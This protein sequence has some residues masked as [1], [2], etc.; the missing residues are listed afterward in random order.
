MTHEPITREP[1]TREPVTRDRW[2]HLFELLALGIALLTIAWG[3]LAQGSTPWWGQ[4]GLTLLGLATWM[5]TLIALSLRGR[6]VTVRPIWLMAIL[7]F[8]GWIW[9][10]TLWAPY[11]LEGYRLAGV[12]T[13]V[14]GVA[15]TL[16]LL[17]T[18][19]RRQTAALTVLV[20]TAAGALALAYLQTRGF[21]VPG[22]HYY[23][24]AGPTLVTGPYFNPSHFSGYLIPVAAVLTSLLLLTRPHLHS[25]VLIGLL[26]LLHWMN[27][28]T[29][30]SSI[31]AVLLATLTPLL[32]W[33]W[34]KNRILGRTL[35]ALEVVVVAVGVPAFL[36]PQGQAFFASHRQLIGLNNSWDQFLQ[37]RRAVWRYGLEVWKAHPL[38]GA[39]S[40]QFLSE[41][42]RY[43]V[44]E[45]ESGSV[46]ESMSVN[47]AHNDLLQI[48]SEFGGVGVLFFVLI[49][50]LP[51]WTRRGGLG[52]LIWW[53]ALP[54]LLVSGIYDAHLSVI[55][56][57]MMTAF[58]LIAL[59]T[60]D[61]KR[62]IKHDSS[63]QEA[64]QLELPVMDGS[65][66]PE[67]K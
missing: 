52:A 46:V 16:H 36:S 19:A 1:V 64:K 8:L 63:E 35:L 11:K 18:T 3:P 9:L 62:S 30:A 58:T 42:P 43:R 25:L 39:G 15:L 23:P 2:T 13:A 5:V 14:L 17:V 57:T 56:G 26:V 67:V 49:L 29:D 24:G 51:L 41:S 45:L 10:S 4:A 66:A 60:V 50:I 55:P 22:F 38:E 12:W 61:T 6:V 47:Y 27:F 21:L 48:A 32:V 33:I 44:S 7:G 54:P 65:P 31:P 34:T 37:G 20:L 28:K 59:A 40:G 53:S